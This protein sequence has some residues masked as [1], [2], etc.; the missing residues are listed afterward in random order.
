[1]G[2]VLV[3]AG[4]LVTPFLCGA[5]FLLLIISAVMWVRED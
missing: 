1:M 3:A 4:V 5:G 2:I